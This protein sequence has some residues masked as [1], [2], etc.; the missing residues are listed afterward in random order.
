MKNQE[1][2]ELGKVLKRWEPDIVIPKGFNHSVW[3]RI[4]TSGSQKQTRILLWLTDLIE[5]LSFKP[6]FA[7][8]ACSLAILLGILTGLAQA[9]NLDQAA[10]SNYQ[11]MVDPYS[12][13]GQSKS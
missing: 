7:A 13:I 1:T 11:Q 2:D 5:D 4:E 8:I 10:K 3:Q 12:R 9:Q 6:A